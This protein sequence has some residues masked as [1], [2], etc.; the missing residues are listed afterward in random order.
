MPNASGVF[1]STVPMLAGKENAN[2]IW[3]YS[4]FWIRS[5]R[6]ELKLIA[7]ANWFPTFP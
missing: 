4:S 3:M 5:T 6:M 7:R 1:I 2:P